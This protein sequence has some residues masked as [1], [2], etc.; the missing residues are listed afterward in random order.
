MA[1]NTA[2]KVQRYNFLG[3]YQIRFSLSI[4][5]YFYEIQDMNSQAIVD[6]KDNLTQ[7]QFFDCIQNALNPTEEREFRDL[8]ASL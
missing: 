6:F 8:V 4:K 7:G 5:G 1:S 3:H 2:F